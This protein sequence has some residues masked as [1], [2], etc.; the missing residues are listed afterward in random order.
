MLLESRHAAALELIGERHER[1]AALEEDLRD[2]RGLYREQIDLLTAGVEP[3]RWPEGVRVCQ[4]CSHCAQRAAAGTRRAG[5][6]AAAAAAAGAG[7]W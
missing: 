1:A 5:G 4:H 3:G 6:A 7:G 2:L